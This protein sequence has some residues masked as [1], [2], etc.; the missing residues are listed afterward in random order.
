MG[1]PRACHF[2][3]CTLNAD[4]RPFESS[5]PSHDAPKR[6]SLTQSTFCCCCS[7]GKI[8][9]KANCLPG[10]TQVAAAFFSATSSCECLSKECDDSGLLCDVACVQFH[11][12]MQ[13]PA[14]TGTVSSSARTE[15]QTA[16]AQ[17]STTSSSSIAA[18]LSP[19]LSSSA[20]ASSLAPSTPTKHQ[21]AVRPAPL[22]QLEKDDAKEGADHDPLCLLMGD[23]AHQDKHRRGMS[24]LLSEFFFLFPPRCFR[25]TARNMDAPPC[26]SIIEH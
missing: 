15:M 12:R 23:P 26:A 3:P 1:G 6:G 14:A 18:P 20:S 16:S 22:Q 8:A 21:E 2:V 11:N 19:S 10:Q 5:Q 4:E 13:A 24:F 9:T 25:L 17:S 7:G